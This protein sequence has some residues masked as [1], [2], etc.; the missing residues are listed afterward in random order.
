MFIFSISFK[1]NEYIENKNKLIKILIEIIAF[2]TLKF[3]E[4]PYLP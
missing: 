3:K 2:L 1:M 4:S